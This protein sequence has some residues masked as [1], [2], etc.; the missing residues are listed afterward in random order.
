ML[1]KALG[2]TA[3]LVVLSA[4]SVA[5]A[6]SR[7]I[8]PPALEQINRA[9]LE[10]RYDD[11]PRA[12]ATLDAQDPTIAALL[13]RAAIARGRYEESL[14]AL[15]PVAQRAPASDAALEYGLLLN[16]LGRADAIAALTRVAAL[17][18]TASDP[19]DLA[20]AA[21]ALRALGRP[22]EANAAYRDAQSM[23]PRDPALNTAWGDLFLEK[24]QKGE[25]VKS[26]QDALKQDPK[27]APAMLGMARALSDENPP[28]AV[29]LA[30]QVLEINPSSVPAHVF[31]AE[32]A[33]DA[34]HRDEA[35]TLLAK[36]LEVNPSSLEARS[37]LAALAYIEDKPAEFEADVAKVLAIAPTYGEA[38]RVTAELAS[39]NFRYEDAAA[40]GRKALA[41]DPKSPRILGDLGTHLLRTG[42]E[43]GAR[44]VLEQS[45]ALDDFDVVTKNLLDMMDKL[46][47]FVTV[48][49]GN[50]IVRLQKDEAPVLADYAVALAHQALDTVSKRYDFTPKGPIL[51]EIF[52]KH[53]DFA[54]RTA[55]LPGMIGALG[56]CFGRVVVMDSPRAR[57]PGEFQWEATL[58]HEL[59]HVVTLQMSNYRVPRWLTEGIS[60]YE[61]KL[62]RAEWGR[63]MDMQFASML[64]DGETLKLRDLNSAFTDPRKISLAYFQASLLVE[65]IVSTY[66]D[67]GLHKL[68]RAYA[69]GLDTDAA[70]KSALNTD[71]DQMQAG[72]DQTL[73]RTFG[74]LRAALKVD[75]DTDLAKMPLDILRVYAGERPGSYP[76]QMVLGVALR[77]AGELDQAVQAFER[78]AAAAPMAVGDDSPHQQI[79][80]IALERKD[81]PRAMTALRAAMDADFDNVGLARKLAALMK[82]NGV[83][84]A[85]RLR[86]VYQRI[87]AVDPFDPDAH[88]ALGR[89][90]MQGNQPVVAVREFKAVLALK[91]VDQAAAFTDL[92]ESYLRSGQRADARRQTLAALEVAP[93]YERAQ[94]LLLE[95]AETKP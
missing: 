12:A 50:L 70:F 66:G 4:I 27:Y 60:V 83:S 9:L 91:P 44:G 51:V 78:A 15:R 75:K 5:V 72:F 71:F 89:L 65:H 56:V 1:R 90:A 20:R 76:A 24:F 67:A 43:P 93:S 34:G 62:H 46:D 30:Q 79:A 47:Q 55:G 6:Q 63:G 88:T 2:L 85:T 54:V 37:L 16:M 81:L 17:A 57:P 95:I 84:D 7:R 69:Q 80:E 92:A 3:A 68:L 14:A 58:W 41:L 28:Q 39:H 13:A 87:V 33:T 77:K 29:K 23:A 86:P 59:A 36:A 53:D 22:H 73:E 11:V 32:Q 8:P 18:E 45:F 64:S 61:E 25:A 40:L 10:G 94:G 26:Y 21:R 35:R 82:Q 49:D 38:Y 19:A 52:P 42:D 74:P 48:R 31:L